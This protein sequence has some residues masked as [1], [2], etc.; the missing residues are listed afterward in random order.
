MTTE[1]EKILADFKQKILSA[2]LDDAKISEVEGNFEIKTAYA[3]GKINFYA[4][5]VLIVEMSV[6]NL[7]DG[8]NKFCLHFE[9]RDLPLAEENFK[10]MLR[11]F[12]TSNEEK[13]LR[14]LFSYTGGLTTGYFAEKLN[15]VSKILSR[16][17][18]FEAMPSSELKNINA[19]YDLIMIA[20]QIAYQIKDI[21]EHFPNTLV[22]KIP[23]KVF[24]KYDA[25]ALI[26]FFNWYAKY[27]G[28]YYGK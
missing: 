23:P 20:P 7:A 17:F 6:T 26:K 12:K 21:S 4:L 19:N 10:A 14:I 2:K 27:G 18:Q 24:A 25:N 28:S 11:T 13:P 8:E 3:E 22:L 15:E 9:L 1:Q 5:N 16:K